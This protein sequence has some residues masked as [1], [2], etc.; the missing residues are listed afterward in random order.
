[1]PGFSDF[2]ETEVLDLLF[3][4]SSIDSIAEDATVSPSTNLWFALHTADPTDAGTQ[5][6][7]E[8]SLTGYARV[9]VARTSSGFSVTGNS[10]RPA[11]NVD[12]PQ[13]TST[14]TATA[15]Y[16]SIGLASAVT[17]GEFICSGSLEPVINLGENVIPRITTASSF[18]LD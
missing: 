17:S 3:T 4:G 2:F 16:A 8:V 12:F 7:N 15:N 11:V 1:M 13:L 9:A 6:S 14:S 18:T 10:V 5:G